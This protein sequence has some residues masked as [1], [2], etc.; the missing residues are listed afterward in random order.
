MLGA[1]NITITNS[2]VVL[3]RPNDISLISVD[4]VN[5]MLYWLETINSTHVAVSIDVK[6]GFVNLSAVCQS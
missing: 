1:R 4:W 6:T 3:N 5:D 2:E